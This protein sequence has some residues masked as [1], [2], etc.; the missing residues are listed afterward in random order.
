MEEARD[1]EL[2]LAIIC[3]LKFTVQFWTASTRFAGIMG[4]PYMLFESPDQI[5]GNGQEGFRRNLCDFGNRKLV[6]A[7]FLN[8]YNDNDRGLS[9]VE[10]AIQEMNDGN[11]EDIVDMVENYSVVEG[12]RR[13]NELRIGG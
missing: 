6:A 10:R 7:H 4:I 13:G 8:V 2:T 3:Q 12:M 9:V 1:L 11:W 5:W